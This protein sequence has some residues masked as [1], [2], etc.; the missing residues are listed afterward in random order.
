[1]SNSIYLLLQYI[2][3]QNPDCRF[4]SKVYIRSVRNIPRIFKIDM[5]HDHKTVFS[6]GNWILLPKS[7]N[8]PQVHI[9]ITS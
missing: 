1:M 5:C 6:F 9:S 4:E 7:E 8:P 3:S 2:E